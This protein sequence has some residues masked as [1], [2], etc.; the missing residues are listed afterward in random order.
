MFMHLNIHEIKN[1]REQK[2]QKGNNK[3]KSKY[4]KNTS[5]LII[6]II[7]LSY[8]I[9]PVS[10]S[11]D[12][13]SSTNIGFNYDCCS[14]FTYDEVYGEM[15][16][17]GPNRICVEVGYRLYDFYYQVYVEG[18]VTSTFVK[19]FAYA[20]AIASPVQSFEWSNHTYTISPNTVYFVGLS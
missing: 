18:S 19:S 15:S 4:I 14:E 16:Y 20:G 5:L 11:S 8:S 17:A 9:I 3:M 12:Y 6:L 10:A 7:L 1:I 13:Y 2:K